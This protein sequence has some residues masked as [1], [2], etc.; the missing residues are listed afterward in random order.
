MVSMMTFTSDRLH[1]NPLEGLERDRN[2]D[3]VPGRGR[4]GWR[5]SADV[6]SQSL[7]KIAERF[8]SA[9]IALGARFRSSLSCRR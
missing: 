8:R 7:D 3:D 9:T 5:R 4:L 1:W 6:R 2:Y